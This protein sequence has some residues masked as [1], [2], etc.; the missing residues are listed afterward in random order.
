MD[1]SWFLNELAKELKLK[2]VDEIDEILSEFEEHF[3]FK[4]DEGYTEEEIV[5]KLAAPKNIASEYS[6][7]S[8][9]VNQNKKLKVGAV[10]AVSPFA[11]I[12]Y[13]FLWLSVVV[14][15]AFS[16]VSFALGFCLLTTLNVG[17]IIPYMPYLPS[18]ILAFAC[19]GLS[20]LAAVGFI[21]YALYVKQWGKVY[22]RWCSNT[23]KG[24]CLPSYSLH[25]KVSKKVAHKLKLIAVI[26]LACFLTAFIVGY[27]VAAIYAGNVEFWH[28]W[29][30]FK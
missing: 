18:F 19:F 7:E 22:L 12:G 9:A 8:P 17:G 2:G 10:A 15:G 30:W 13:A 3:R 28:V 27:I 6:A 21:Y 24:G 11:A 14:L 23:I 20:L 29:N 26:A 16:L 5:K 4:A 1:K 25:P